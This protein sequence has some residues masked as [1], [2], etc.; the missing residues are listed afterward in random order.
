MSEEAYYLI[1]KCCLKEQHLVVWSQ[2]VVPSRGLVRCRYRLFTSIC[3]KAGHIDINRLSFEAYLVLKEWMFLMYWKQLW[4]I[5]GNSWWCHLWENFN[6]WISL[7]CSTVRLSR[8]KDLLMAKS[9]LYVS[10]TK[11]KKSYPWCG[12]VWPGE[13]L[14]WTCRHCPKQW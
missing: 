6:V 2:R 11:W 7:I 14:Y 10:L 9:F 8:S 12:F 1:N 4:K 3:S 13:F 5:D